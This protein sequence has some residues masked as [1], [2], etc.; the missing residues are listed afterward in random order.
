MP[1][2]EPVLASPLPVYLGWCSCVNERTT[3]AR[4][5]QSA[6]H[7]APILCTLQRGLCNLCWQLGAQGWLCFG[8]ALSPPALSCLCCCCCRIQVG[9]SHLEHGPS[10]AG[11]ISPCKVSAGDAAFLWG[12][13]WQ[14]LHP[15]IHD[16]GVKFQQHKQGE[17]SGLGRCLERSSSSGRFWPRSSTMELLGASPPLAEIK[18]KSLSLKSLF[19]LGG[20]VGSRHT[21]AQEAPGQG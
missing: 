1:L 5:Q 12:H 17:G 2:L 6:L 19:S 15:R 11:N 3:P 8:G 9:R 20:V 4:S 10:A 14:L 21:A 16:E 18:Q 7:S 13:L